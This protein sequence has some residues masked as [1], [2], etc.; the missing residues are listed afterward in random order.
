MQADMHDRLE[1]VL[2]DLTDHFIGPAI[3]YQNLK[4]QCQT[5]TSKEQFHA[6]LGRVRATPFV[7]RLLPEQL[8]VLTSMEEAA[9][10]KPLDAGLRF[11]EGGIHEGASYGFRFLI[12]N[13]TRASEFKNVLQALWDTKPVDA[14]WPRI[15]D[16]VAR[17]KSRWIRDLLGGHLPSTTHP[18]IPHLPGLLSAV[19]MFE[20]Y[21]PR[22]SLD[23]GVVEIDPVPA[24]PV[25]VDFDNFSCPPPTASIIALPEVAPRN[26]RI[27]EWTLFGFSVGNQ[28]QFT[29]RK[30]PLIGR[31]VKINPQSIQIFV[32]DLNATRIVKRPQYKT[33][34][35]LG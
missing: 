27:K 31:V 15:R 19:A 6:L 8:A 5:V 9:L 28:V 23:L 14:D 16:T 17:Y 25:Y 3:T 24:V 21:E 33:I 26:P 11:Y 34:R 18:F 22:V 29:K 1:A 30:Q 13:F 2:V 10:A 20:T 35:F 4:A 32:A 7:A 12:K